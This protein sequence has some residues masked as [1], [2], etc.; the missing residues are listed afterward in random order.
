MDNRI[1]QKM[2]RQLAEWL[3]KDFELIID[4]PTEDDICQVLEKHQEKI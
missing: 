4:P 1:K 2:A 3:L